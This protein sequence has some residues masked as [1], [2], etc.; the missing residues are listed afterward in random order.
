MLYIE[1]FVVIILLFLI[2]W[3]CLGGCCV[4]MKFEHIRTDKSIT[5]EDE[6]CSFDVPL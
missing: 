2:V 1:S 3:F 5:K 4:V 6:F